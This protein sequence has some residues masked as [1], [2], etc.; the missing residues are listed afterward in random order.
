M[1]LY[2]ARHVTGVVDAEPLGSAMRLSNPG[3]TERAGRATDGFLVIVAEGGTSAQ[4]GAWLIIRG[5]RHSPRPAARNRFEWRVRPGVWKHL[6][7]M[8]AGDT[9]VVG[10]G[11]GQHSRSL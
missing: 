3:S 6:T 4:C 1:S 5:V 7:A 9:I 11:C 8:R 2:Y 10:F